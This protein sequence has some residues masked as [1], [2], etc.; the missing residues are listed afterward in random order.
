MQLKFL[1]IGVVAILGT[2]LTPLAHAGDGA[3][4]RKLINSQGCK[5][6][7]ALSGDGG[8]IGGGFEAMSDKLTR[9]QIRSKLVNPQKKHGNNKIPD[10]SHLTDK[11]I[12]ALVKFIQT[13]P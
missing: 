9:E 6:C 12:D 3:K 8:V 10:F 2:T 7:H 1:I 13:E 11:D 4:A 5:A